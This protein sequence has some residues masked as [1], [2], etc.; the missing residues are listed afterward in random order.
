MG[1]T[2]P[3]IRPAS[4][5]TATASPRLPI[6]VCFFSYH[7]A[8]VLQ[9]R[10]EGF[11]G[12]ELEMYTVASALAKDPEFRLSLV[13]VCESPVAPSAGIAVTTVKPPRS[14]SGSD[15]R[16]ARFSAVSN[17]CLR[18][19]R[20]LVAQ[21]PDL[22]FCKLA[23]LE[24]ILVHLAASIRRRPFVFRVEHDWE[25]DFTDLRDKLLGGNERI[26][27]RFVT[28][29]RAAEVVIVQTTFQQQRLLASYDI[30][31][32][33]IPNAHVIPDDPG[34]VGRSTI[35]WVARCHP[36]KQPAEFLKLAKALPSANF[37][38]VCP[39]AKGSEQ[40]FREVSS[41][42]MGIQNL[43]FI[44]GVPADSMRP[45]YEKARVFV[46]TSRAEGF[47]NVIIE[48]M[49]HKV[50][51]VSLDFNPDGILR[52][53]S[54]ENRSFGPYA[55]HLENRIVGYCADRSPEQLQKLVQ[56]LNSNDQLWDKCANDAYQFAKAAFSVDSVS[57]LYKQLFQQL[58]KQGKGYKSG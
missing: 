34:L 4:S 41:E 16:V 53:N 24:S 55:Q 37:V 22:Y 38:M 10:S 42:A 32:V 46:L 25:T 58:K 12:A 31:S 11:G 3:I 9:G 49:K 52:N 51:V 40:L 28:M 54:G 6:R 47:S 23:S 48:A 5:S 30:N 44:P 13:T 2:T 19:F 36:M 21:K 15:S 17:Y 50:P 45:L 18:L 7:I 33:L 27:K 43:Q 20:A 26:A 56:A 39:A 35:L 14:L 1:L 29:L 8:E 57:Q